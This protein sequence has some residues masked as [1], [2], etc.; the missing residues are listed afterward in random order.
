[1]NKK[2]L[3]SLSVIG[4]VAAIAIGGTIAFFSDTETSTGNTFTAGALDLKV[5]NTCHYNGGVCPIDPKNPNVITTWTQTDLGVNHKFFWFSDVKPGDW[6]EDTISLHVDNDACLQLVI[7]D[8]VD[9]DNTCTE[10]E[11]VAEG[12]TN[13]GITTEGEPAGELRENVLFAMWLDQGAIFGFQGATGDSTEC[14]NEQNGSY[15]P[16]IITEGP[17]NEGGETWNLYDY[18]GAYLKGGETACFGVSWTVPADVGNEI[19]SDSLVADMTFN[20]IQHRHNET[21]DF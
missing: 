16:T 17:I 2:I 9:N 3:I 20:V 21:C 10:P 5:D 18:Q 12:D 6:G 8:P 13:C 11:G 14:D 1:M 4:A 15:E 7:S 19:Q